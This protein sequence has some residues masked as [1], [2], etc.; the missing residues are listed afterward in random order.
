MNQPAAVRPAC[1][2]TAAS[3]ALA[4]TRGPDWRAATKELRGR[5]RAVCDPAQFVEADAPNIA[6]NT[7]GR[8]RPQ[9]SASC[10]VLSP[11]RNRYAG[12]PSISVVPDSMAPDVTLRS[13]ARRREPLAMTAC[14]LPCPGPQ[15]RY[16][17]DCRGF[18]D[19]E[20]T[21]AKSNLGNGGT[22]ACEHLQPEVT[23]RLCCRPAI[24]Q[25]NK[26]VYGQRTENLHHR[27]VEF[28]V[29][30]GQLQADETVQQ[31]E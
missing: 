18:H 22:K 30:I 17:L 26:E 3:D 25:S 2:P 9:T 6:L 5:P 10:P 7:V 14:S 23:G 16:I 27:V 21:T 19:R 12:E 28:G 8:L 29:V 13:Q 4:W 1:G 11:S 15:P 24:T 20:H 31:R